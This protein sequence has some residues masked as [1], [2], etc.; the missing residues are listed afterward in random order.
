MALSSSSSSSFR[1][2]LRDISDES[3]EKLFFFLACTNNMHQNWLNIRKRK[4]FLQLFFRKSHCL[5][6]FQCIVKQRQQKIASPK[7]IAWLFEVSFQ[8]ILVSHHHCKSCCAHLIL[9][10]V[11]FFYHE[12]VLQKKKE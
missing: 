6:A 1:N 3:T 7:K 9:F 10:H 11:I 2:F 4:N 8:L 12:N 5:R